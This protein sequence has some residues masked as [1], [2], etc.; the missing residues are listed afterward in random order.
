MSKLAQ[1]KEVAK[2]A[3]HTLSALDAKCLKYGD[4]PPVHWNPL[5]DD[6]DRWRLCKKCKINIDWHDCC[7]WIRM[8]DELIQIWWGGDTGITENEAPVLV[9]AE[10]GR[11]M[12]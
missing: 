4:I 10:I 8:P 6:G 3:E 1:I 12:T 2:A 9:A 7:A 11:K 5:T